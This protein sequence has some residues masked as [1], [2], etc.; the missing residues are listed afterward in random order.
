MADVGSGSL[1][2]L[3]SWGLRGTMGP[4]HFPLAEVVLLFLLGLPR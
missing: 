4:G 3:D 2:L 1:S